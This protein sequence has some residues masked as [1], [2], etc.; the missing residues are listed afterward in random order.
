MC[1]LHA[2]KAFTFTIYNLIFLKIEFIVKFIGYHPVEHHHFIIKDELSN[3]SRYSWKIMDR[4]NPGTEFPSDFS[5][6]KVHFDTFNI[7]SI[8]LK[9]ELEI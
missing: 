4:F 9:C 7:I 1:F 6:I 2:Q 8:V 5:L 3:Y